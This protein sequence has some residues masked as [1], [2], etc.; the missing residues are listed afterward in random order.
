MALV[1]S[2]CA[3]TPPKPAEVVGLY[4]PINKPKVVAPV[5]EAVPAQKQA[6]VAKVKVV[7]KTK[8][9]G[10]REKKNR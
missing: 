9:G 3:A 1:I 2:G 4:R 7:S 5:A 10:K 8:K 6:P